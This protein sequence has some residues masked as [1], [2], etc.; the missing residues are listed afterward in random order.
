MLQTIH[1]WYKYLNHNVIWRSIDMKRVIPE[2]ATHGGV[3]RAAQ[4]DA[5]QSAGKKL[6]KKI[7]HSISKMTVQIKGFVTVCMAEN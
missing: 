4:W 1:V 2:R 5:E 3:V 6:L 7:L